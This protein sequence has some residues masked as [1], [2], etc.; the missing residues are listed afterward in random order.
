MSGMAVLKVVQGQDQNQDQALEES[1]R[2]GG[3]KAAPSNNV[4]AGGGETQ[5]LVSG[6]SV[7]L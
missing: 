5:P 3:E 7:D 1:R 6:K 2:A 4:Q